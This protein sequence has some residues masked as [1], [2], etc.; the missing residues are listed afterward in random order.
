MVEP[1][2][3]TC[4]PALVAADKLEK[5]LGASLNNHS[6]QT[7]DLEMVVEQ[8]DSLIGNVVLHNRS[9]ENLGPVVV[10]EDDYRPGSGLV[11][12]PSTSMYCAGFDSDRS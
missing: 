10:E 2:R 5:M 1:E 11:N 4:T 9:V 6:C 7:V 8:L 3:S 12:D